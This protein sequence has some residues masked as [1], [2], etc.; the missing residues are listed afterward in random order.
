MKSI[1]LL[2]C[3]NLID[4]PDGFLAA[5]DDHLV[6]ELQSKGYQVEFVAWNRYTP[7]ER[8][9]DLVLVRMTWDYV[10][11]CDE[12]LAKMKE[13]SDSGVP[14]YNPYPIL[15]WNSHKSYLSELARQG[16]STIDTQ[17]LLPGDSAQ[18]IEFEIRKWKTDE[19]IF[20]PA[21]SATSAGLTR[22]KAYQLSAAILQAQA[23]GQD[24]LIQPFMPEV[25]SGEIS[26]HFFGKR[27]S[28]A[29]IKRP[30]EGD[31][32]VQ[33]A[34]GGKWTAYQPTSQEVE[35]CGSILKLIPDPLLIA[36]VDFLPTVQGPK[37]MELELI[38]PLL[39]FGAA[40]RTAPQNLVAALLQYSISE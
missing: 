26:L 25:L 37:L 1:C 39:F 4:H 16:V 9:D 10:Q 6:R 31:F 22:V 21:V 32:R 36:R 33:D 12:F 3:E 17:M 18:A 20:K 29:V 28:H 7:S 5:D 11:R 15:K 38:E 23:S 19:W 30:A 40:P 14:L 35:F 34:F 8:K 13:I 24:Y 2:I 27:Y